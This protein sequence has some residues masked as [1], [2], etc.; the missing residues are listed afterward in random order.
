MDRNRGIVPTLLLSLA[1]AGCADMESGAGPTAPSIAPA[2][3]AA[4]AATAALNGPGWLDPAFGVGGKVQTN[5]NPN[6]V[7]NVALQGDG[8]I[9]V[10]ASLADFQIASLVFGVLRYLPG[11]A[12]DPGFGRGG[13]VRTAFTI[14]FHYPHSV[15][16]QPDGKIVVAGSASSPNNA[17]DQIAVARYN[18]DGSLDGSFGKGGKVTTVLL[19][20]SDVANVVVVQPDKKILIG[21]FALTCFGRRCGQN[22]A[23]VR[24]NANGE[25]DGTFGNG[26]S[27]VA[28]SIGQVDALALEQDGS[29]LAL[30]RNGI[31]TDAVARFSATG[32][33]LPVAL[34]GRL[35]RI[36]NTG[37]ATFQPDGKI[38]LGGQARGICKHGLAVH[39]S[40]RALDDT[41]DPAFS[42]PSFF[43]GNGVCNGQD[44]AQAVAVA[45]SG[46]IVVGGIAALPNFQTAFGVARLTSG[47]SLDAGWGTGG[48]VTTIFTGRDDQV[49]ALAVQP[50]GKVVAVG[51]IAT[52]DMGNT[53][54]ALTRYR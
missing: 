34:T 54:V 33:V 25:L 44:L 36:S 24:Y 12:L 2:A 46:K 1:I 35:A 43:Y 50:D 49:D 27:V 38:V 6:Q 28:P 13:I 19:G 53:A 8:K 29:I 51:L 30:D 5:I 10:V 52:D 4:T 3:T 45:S 15:A 7:T 26:G 48:R 21:G 18:A 41:V 31:G 22:T 40:R 23:L 17:T 47:G 20:F 37:P 11:G 9:V 14:G 39:V 16:I 42:S 32:A